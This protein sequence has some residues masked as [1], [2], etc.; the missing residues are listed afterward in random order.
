MNEEDQWVHTV[1]KIMLYGFE[2]DVMT[3]VYAEEEMA[4]EQALLL[5]SMYDNVTIKMKSIKVE[6]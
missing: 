4:R 5:Q 6:K 1:T 3:W 2:L